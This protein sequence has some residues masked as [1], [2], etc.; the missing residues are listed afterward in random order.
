MKLC[1]LVK[2]KLINDGDESW[3]PTREVIQE[4]FLIHVI[5]ASDIKSA[6]KRVRDRATARKETTQPFAVIVGE[7]LHNI[8]DC[9]IS[10]D[11]ILYNVD[12]PVK[13]IDVTFK[14]FQAIHAQYPKHAEPLWLLL[15]ICVYGIKTKWDNSKH[16]HSLT[17]LIK[18]LKCVD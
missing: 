8:T 9:Y 18:D 14:I 13:A 6:I 10:V 11:N 3:K 17:S 1:M 4:G 7:D 12:S 15:Q 2:P 5:S 16:M